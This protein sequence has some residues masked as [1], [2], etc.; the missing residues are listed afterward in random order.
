M[1]ESTVKECH[2]RSHQ[3]DEGGTDQDPARVTALEDAR[4]VAE[5]ESHQPLPWFLTASIAAAMAS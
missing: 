2:T 1:D 5:D 3:Q 4:V